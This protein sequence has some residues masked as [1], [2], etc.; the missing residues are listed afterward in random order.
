MVDPC[1]TTPLNFNS[2]FFQDM[3]Y[4]LFDPAATQLWTPSDLINPDT[5]VDCGLISVNLIGIADKPFIEDNRSNSSSNELSV[6]FSDDNLIVGVFPVDV[7][8]FY[9]NYPD[10]SVTTV[11]D[12]S[13]RVQ[14][15]CDTGLS[16]TP[17]DLFD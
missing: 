14:E 16:M 5:E 12:F 3:S 10:N 1:L 11:N 9:T 6:P 2:G 4:K 8:V 13:I 15:N 7:Q 17:S